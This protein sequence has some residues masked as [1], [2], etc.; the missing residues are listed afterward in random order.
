MRRPLVVEREAYAI[1]ADHMNAGDKRVFDSR[2]ALALGPLPMRIVGRMGRILREGVQ[3]VGQHQ[4]LMLLFVMQPYLDD[5][6]DGIAILRRFDQRCHGG[7]DV[8]TIGRRFGNAGPRD[9]AALRARLP[10]TGRH[11]I[12]IEQVSESL[13]ERAIGR[14]ERPQQKLLEEPRHVGAMPLRRARLGHRLHHLVFSGKWRGAALG[15]GAHATKC[16]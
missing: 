10:R 1:V 11:V 15:L 4:F 7:V 6:D 2:R 12:G 13:I 16:V 3:E 9:Q 14:S 8:R 5:G